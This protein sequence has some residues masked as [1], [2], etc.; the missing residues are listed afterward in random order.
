MT[1]EG[2]RHFHTPINRRGLT[3]IPNLKT[4][5]S[6]YRLYHSLNPDIV[7]HFTI[8]PVIF[9][10]LIARSC[11]KVKII[12]NVTGLGYVFIGTT[13]VHAFLRPF[14]KWMYKCVLRLS[15]LLIFQNRDDRSF[16]IKSK[17]I[18]ENIPPSIII[19]GSGVDLERFHKKNIGEIKPEVHFI[20]VARMLYDKGIQEYI[21]AAKVVKKLFEN[22]IFH[23]VGDID[24]GNPTAISLDIINEWVNQ[25]IVNYHGMVDD[26]RP[27]LEMA[28]VFIL[29][30]YREGLSKSIIEALAMEL[31]IITTD[32]PG[33]RETV[34]HKENGLLIR[35]YDVPSLINAITYMIKNPDERI[36]MGKIS[37]EIAQT[38]FDLEI[39]NSKYLYHMNQC[40]K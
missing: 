27:F 26:V 6:V 34:I 20:L 16:F 35:P 9:G 5:V 37:R 7:V 19:N 14:V 22:I 2:I 8:K 25:G 29:P 11:T 4:I 23:L 10:T 28:D 3:I 17:I 24:E 15:D 39:I 36:L 38:K 21:E 13:F 40:L 33:C 12:N 31:P 30:S 32:V 18:A 1:A